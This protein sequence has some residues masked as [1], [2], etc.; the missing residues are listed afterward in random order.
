[1]DLILIL[2]FIITDRAPFETSPAALAEGPSLELWAGP[3]DVPEAID[4]QT[5]FHASVQGSCSV[6]HVGVSESA[7]SLDTVM[8]S[9]NSFTG[10]ARKLLNATTGLCGHFNASQIR[11]LTESGGS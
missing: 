8:S 4:H 10:G 5:A 2:D 9:A 3:K 7:Q 11:N 6:D 1:M